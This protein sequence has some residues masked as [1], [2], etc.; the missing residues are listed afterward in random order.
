MLTHYLQ[1][2]IAEGIGLGIRQAPVG[3]A[4]IRLRDTRLMV[5][6]N[7]FVQLALRLV[8]VTQHH[9]HTRLVSCARKVLFVNRYGL[10]DS[11]YPHECARHTQLPSR[12]TWL[13]FG[14]QPG[15]LERCL[16][17]SFA[18]KDLDVVTARTDVVGRQFDATLQQELGVVINP[19]ANTDICEKA[20]RFD[21]MLVVLQEIA[22]HP[23]RL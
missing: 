3:V 13:L 7:C 20:H 11:T 16:K 2:V 15:L 10:I 18:I 1:L 23:F 14:E 21:V 12:I 19:Q 8:G 17:L 22:A 9:V 6:V 5:G 4:I